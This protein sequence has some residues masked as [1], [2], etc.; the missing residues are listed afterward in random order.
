MK[1]AVI[2]AGSW[3]TALAQ[4]AARAGHEVSLWARRPEV[5][6]AINQTGCNPDYLSDR[7]L[8]DSIRATSDLEEAVA[9]AA[10]VLSVTPSKVMRQSAQ[11]LIQAGVADDAVVVTCTKGVEGETGLVPVQILGE[12]LG[13][14]D[15]LACLSGPNHAEEVIEGVPAG[16]V[17]ASGDGG[18][19][20]FVQEALGSAEFR[21]YTS[22]DPLGVELCAAA[23]NVVAIAVGVSY[24]LG[25]G[26]NTAAML[27]TRGQAEMGRLVQACGGRSITCMGLA[28]TGDLIATCMSRHSRNRTF[29]EALAAGESL[30]QF[31]ARRHMV[32]EGAAACRS[33]VALSERVGVELPLAQAVFSLVVEE[34]DP[35][36][37][38]RALTARSP[39]PEFY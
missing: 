19:A 6:R 1:V 32:V 15:R 23:K 30:E 17:V 22:D 33:L 34:A 7:V 21:I 10:L 38:G 16:T 5:A 35:A 37:V 4:V 27:M 31:E 39:K 8:L 26:D 2:G 14:V 28:G 9:G 20:Q 18:A 36:Q 29:G 3:G 24:G 12:V 13:G 11:A 25:F